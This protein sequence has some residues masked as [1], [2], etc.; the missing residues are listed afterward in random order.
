[1]GPVETAPAPEAPYDLCVGWMTVEHLHDPIKALRNL[2]SWTRNGGWLAISLPNAASKEFTL[3]GDSWFALELPRHLYHFT[4]KT[5]HSALAG[6][7]WEVQHIYHQRNVDN[8]I[9]SCGYYLE[10]ISSSRF[11]QKLSRQFVR[12]PTN[13]PLHFLIYPLLFPIACV[14][15]TFGQTGRMTVL[16]KKADQEWI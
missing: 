7:G 9:A 8:L 12:F 14:L 3:F 13:V 1:V 16:A 10:N 5:I 6:A 2:A 4:P 15:A 11:F